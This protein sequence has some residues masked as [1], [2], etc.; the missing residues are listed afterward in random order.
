[1]QNTQTTNI[2][3]SD[4][5]KAVLE[6]IDAKLHEIYP[7]KE[8]KEEVLAQIGEKTF[9]QTLEKVLETFVGKDEKETDALQ[10]EFTILMEQ[11]KTEEALEFAKGKGVDADKIFEEV[12]IE[13]LADVLGYEEDEVTESI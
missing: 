2:Q 5:M 9:S 10:E 7:T 11:G 1:M 6:K 8:E 3:I 13:L 12:S 4:E